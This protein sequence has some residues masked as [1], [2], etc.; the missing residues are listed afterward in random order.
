[1]VQGVFLLHL[2]YLIKTLAGQVSKFWDN[3]D[4]RRKK[5]SSS[6]VRIIVNRDGQAVKESL[7]H[8]A[9]LQLFDR[10]LSLLRT[11]SGGL[12]LSN[13]IIFKHSEGIVRARDVA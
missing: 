13:P 2:A 7:P 8:A 9:E 10:I 12:Q 6:N 1:M 3:Q 5:A 4:R 11:L